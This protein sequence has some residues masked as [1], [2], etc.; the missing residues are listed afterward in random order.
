MVV[1]DDDEGEVSFELPVGAAHGVQQVA[2]VVTLDQVDHD[3]GV[4]LGVEGMAI[5][6]E[7]RLQLAVVLD[8]PVQDDRELPV[9]AAG[10]RMRVLLV[11]GA[12]GGPAGVAEAGRRLGAVRA[13]LPLQRLEIADD[14]DVVESAVLAQREPGRVVAPVLETLEALE[15]QVFTGS[16]ADVSD[17]P[18]HARNL[19]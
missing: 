3:L 14:A 9:V 16:L 10:Q 5:G 1:V 2:L 17:D 4:G 11:H 13:G 8:D 6:F 15:Q 12:V 18:A 7:R 19:P